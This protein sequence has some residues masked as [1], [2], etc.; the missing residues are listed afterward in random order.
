[1][2]IRK[3]ISSLFLIVV[4]VVYSGN[5]LDTD[6]QQ[7]QVLRRLYGMMESKETFMSEKEGRISAIKMMLAT[8][9]IS[10]LQQ[11]EINLQ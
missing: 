11:Y 6:T 3:A 4:S 10:N 9:N 7:D 8:P 2:N 1:M 5:I